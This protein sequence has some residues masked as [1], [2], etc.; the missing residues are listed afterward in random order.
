V[1]T[2]IDR[3]KVEAVTSRFP[4]LAAHPDEIG[5]LAG[6]I[7]C[8]CALGGIINADSIP[9]FKV[10]MIC[11][12]ANNQLRE[13]RDG[14]EVE[15]RGILYAPDYIVNAGGTI[16]DTDRLN[17]GGFNRERAMAN[18]SRIYETMSSLIRIAREESIPT[19]RAADLLAERRIDAVR[20]AKL[21]AARGEIRM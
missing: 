1:V 4:A 9:Q 3:E 13:E 19:Y 20:K 14:Q 15:A 2:D 12:S 11:G 6:D 7:F 17:P 16:F 21:L 10:K 8:P 18:V 5:G